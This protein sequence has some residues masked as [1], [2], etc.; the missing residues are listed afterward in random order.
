[1]QVQK[2]YHTHPRLMMMMMMTLLMS[3]TAMAKLI[4]DALYHSSKYEFGMTQK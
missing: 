4:V 2:L 3:A 1:M